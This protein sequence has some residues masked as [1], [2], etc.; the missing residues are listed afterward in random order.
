[1]LTAKPMR[2]TIAALLVLAL[3]AAGHSALWRWTSGQ[4]ERGFAAWTAQRR[5]Q[6]WMVEHGPTTRGGWPFAATV[7]IPGLRMTA[8]MPNLPGGIDWQ[9]EAVALRVAAPRLDRLLVD[10]RGRQRL[11][12]GETELPFAA[13]R[14]EAAFPTGAGNTIREGEVKAE[15]LRM[16]TPSGL[17]ELR[18]GTLAFGTRTSATEN[19]P[20][21]SVNL[22][23]RGLGLPEGLAALP[24][25]AAFGRQVDSLVAEALVSGPLPG[26]RDPVVR[27]EQWRDGGGT[28]EIRLL[29]LQWGPVGGGVNATVTLDDRLQP[30]GTATV[31]MSGAD[32]V[33]RALAQ[34]GSLPPASAAAAATALILLQRAPENGG[35][36][37]VEVPMT[38]E[39]SR[40]TVARVPLARIAPIPWP[41]RREADI[42]PGEDPTLPPRR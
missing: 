36:P 41:P 8:T 13:D 3:L 7:T 32:Q 34:A 29:A 5:A 28:L 12:L 16:N 33:I 10:L 23:L 38:L 40:L 9:A 18:E 30:M 31:R 27:A 15:R 17:L 37:Q 1:M 24:A 35:P 6:G 2:A 11:R 14:L 20:A 26:G 22:A 42:T 19:E 39:G 21:L 25:L 4:I